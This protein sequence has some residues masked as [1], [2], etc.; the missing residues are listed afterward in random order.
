M[1]ASLF[2]VQSETVAQDR[3][4]TNPA[5]GEAPYSDGG[6][7]ASPTGGLTADL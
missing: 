2:E 6:E 7:T 1:D 4:S 5:K 3:E